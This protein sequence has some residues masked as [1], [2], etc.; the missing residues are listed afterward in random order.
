VTDPPRERPYDPDEH[1]EVLRRHRGRRTHVSRRGRRLLVLAGFVVLLA[2]I[3]GAVTLWLTRGPAEEASTLTGPAKQVQIPEGMAADAVAQLLQT[4]GIVA[5][6]SA[7]ANE[8]QARGAAQDLKSGTYSLTP[9]ESVDSILSKLRGGAVAPS[10]KITFPEGLSI[11][12]AAA[13]LTAQ[14]L[15]DG[16]EYARLASQ[17]SHFTVPAVGDS[18]PKVTTLEGLLFPET[19]FLRADEL[20][21][22]LIA[23]QLTEFQ[24][25]TAG[26]PWA[27]TKDLGVTPYQIVII[28]S[29]IEK[30]VRVPAERAK[31]AAVIYNRI[32]KKMPLGIDA[33]TR[34]AVKK[35]TEPLTKSD[36]ESDS[37]YNTR[38]AVGLPPGPIA[39]P[40]LASL[41]AALQPAAVDYLY[42]VLQDEAGHHF[43]TNSYDAFLKAQKNA[44]P[45]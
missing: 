14:H 36:L 17:P 24:S 18:T 10:K 2:L 27:R 43:F 3:A 37:A 22:D 19:Y 1:L 13:R 31:V 6:A 30:E 11:D 35:W 29:L 32:A 4:E 42:Y 7:F 26:L 16:G 21:V 39:S 45:Q 9:G 25:Q 41:R 38:K 8:V 15:L 23:R 34:Y 44:P 5:S 12:Q 40:G 28:A 20:P 33:S